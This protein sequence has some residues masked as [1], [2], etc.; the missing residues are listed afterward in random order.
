LAVASDSTTPVSN[1]SSSFCPPDCCD[2]VNCMRYRDI[3]GYTVPVSHEILLTFGGAGL[4]NVT[5]N[6]SLLFNDCSAETILEADS[7][8]PL[9]VTQSC[10]LEFLNELWRYDIN[11]DTWSYLEPTYPPYQ[12]NYSFPFPRHSHAAVLVQLVRWEPSTKAQLLQKFMYVY[13]G[14]AYECKDPCDDM[15]RFEIPWASQMYYPRPQEG[16]FWNRAGYWEQIVNEYSPGRRMGHGMVVSQDY[17]FIYLFGG[18]GKGLFS[19]LWRY[20]TYGNKWEELITYG[21]EKVVRTVTRWDGSSYELLL[22][23]SDK[24][25]ND[26]ITYS[27]TGSKPENRMSA[28]LLYFSGDS[29]YLFLFGGLGTRVRIFNLGNASVAL[30]D[31]WVFSL[32][33][34]EWTQIFSDTSGPA[35][36]FEAN[37]IVLAT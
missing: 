15:W 12:A 3:D 36:R 18:L 27:A 16:G 34:Q 11:A 20:D 14:F 7:D 9:F 31:F 35:A 6:D 8:F 24:R 33:N 10:G 30:G 26:T 19:D 4:R 22:N 29:D 13:G 37:I 5:V 32:S 21:I 2:T 23:I 25:L 1:L 17:K 28:C